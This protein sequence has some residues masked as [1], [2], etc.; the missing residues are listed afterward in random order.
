[1][2]RL[3]M[4]RVV[5]DETCVLNRDDLNPN[6]R[7]PLFSKVKRECAGIGKASTGLELIWFG[8]ALDAI[9]TRLPRA[10]LALTVSFGSIP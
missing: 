4:D 1:M 8:S 7:A 2:Q 6:W 3:P 5:F 9:D 10:I